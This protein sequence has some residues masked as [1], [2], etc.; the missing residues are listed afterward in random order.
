MPAAGQIRLGQLLDV[1]AV[2][3]LQPSSLSYRRRPLAQLAERRAPPQLERGRQR[4][5]SRFP[6]A[7]CCACSALAD[8]LL[9]APHVDRVRRDSQHIAPLYGVN[10]ISAEGLAQ[11]HDDVPEQ[12]EARSWRP[13][14]PHRIGQLIGAHDLPC[15]GDQ[16]REDHTVLP[17][18]N[19]HG[20]GVSSDLEGAEN[21]KLDR[22][23]VPPL[24]PIDTTTIPPWHQPEHPSCSLESGAERGQQSE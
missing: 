16:Y 17:G 9:E 21:R 19:P 10:H 14:T 2:Q 7:L 3:L 15:P 24:P 8:H 1:T 20:T 4:D 5:G 12:L 23:Q 11:T 13:I 6:L 18:T 22:H